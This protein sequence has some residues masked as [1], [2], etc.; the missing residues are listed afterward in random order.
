M[1]VPRGLSQLVQHQVALHPPR[2]SWKMTCEGDQGRLGSFGRSGKLAYERRPSLAIS[3][4][5]RWPSV[6]IGG[7][8]WPSA[9]IRGHRRP[10]MATP[11]PLCANLVELVVV[12]AALEAT[13]GSLGALEVEHAC[14]RRARGGEGL[15]GGIKGSSRGSEGLKRNK[16]VQA[17]V[18]GGRREGSAPPRAA[19]PRGRDA[20]RLRRGSALLPPSSPHSSAIARW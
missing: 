3:K 11:R 8:P 7:H 4:G 6:A 13:E 17:H 1:S 19:R 14:L 16:K 15:P 10:S 2:R 12:G 5:R 9:A 20:G 18:G